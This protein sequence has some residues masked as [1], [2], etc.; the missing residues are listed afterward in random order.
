MFNNIKLHLI[1]ELKEIKNTLSSFVILFFLIFLLT[2]YKDFFGETFHKYA[3]SII[4]EAFTIYLIIGLFCLTPF[5]FFFK[6][7][8]YKIRKRLLSSEKDATYTGVLQFIS[9]NKTIVFWNLFSGLALSLAS[10]MSYDSPITPMFTIAFLL[11][12]LVFSGVSFIVKYCKE[13]AIEQF[14]L[15]YALAIIA[16]VVADRLPI[17]I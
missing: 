17:P 12:W 9:F 3:T 2:V 10:Q 15:I 11:I 16:L 14:M 5:Y 8:V 4:K 7:S 6:K 1:D 13:R